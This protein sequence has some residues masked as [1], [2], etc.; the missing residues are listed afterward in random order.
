MIYA[1]GDKVIF[2][3][4]ATPFSYGETIE[5]FVVESPTKPFTYYR[6]IET[7][8]SNKSR[9]TGNYPNYGFVSGPENIT[10][11]IETIR[12]YKLQEL[13]IF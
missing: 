12:K 1:I 10:P 13:G 4:E 3:R 5:C 8:Y 7:K 6:L 2:H 11:H 9:L